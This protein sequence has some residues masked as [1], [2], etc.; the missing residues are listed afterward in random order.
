MLLKKLIKG[1]KPEYQNININDLCLDSRKAKRG[2]L[3]FAIKGKNF[4]GSCFIEEAISKGCKVIVCEKKNKIK[5]KKIPILKV[6]NIRL[7]LGECCKIFYQKKPNNIIAVTGTNGKS[8]VAEFYSQILTMLNTPVASIGTLGI[9]INNKIK[10]KNNLT[11]LDIISLHKELSRIKKN[12]VNHVILEASSHGLIQ[13]RL[14]GIE[15]NCGIFTNFSQ[16]HLDYHKSMRCY[17]FAKLILFNNLLKRKKYLITN[18]NIKEFSNLKKIIKRKKLRLLSIGNNLSTIKIASNYYEKNYQNISFEYKKKR[19]HIKI[20]LVGLFQIEN[21]F[22]AVLAVIS[23]KF[24]IRQILPKLKKIKEVNGRL[25]LIR[26]LPNKT[27]VFV[28]FAH[29]PDAIKKT[30]LTLKEHYNKNLIIIFGCG[31]ERDQKKRPLMA[32]ISED[33]CNQ[34][35]I[36]DD[37]PRNE[38]P[39]LIRKMII[40][41]FKNKTKVIEIPSRTK[42]I[43]SAILNSEPESIILVAGKGHE[44]TQIY[45]NK[46][47]NISDRKIIKKIKCK[48]LKHDKK[49]YREA[50]NKK[51]IKE[52]IN[53]KK[54]Y[55]FIGTTINS[56][57][58]KQGN[59]FIAIKGKKKDGHNY[60]NEAIKNKANYCVISKKI[61]GINNKKLINC[62]N[63][64]EFLNRLAFL[65]RKYSKAKIIAITGS[66]GKTSAKSMLG[67]I[68]SKYGK[69]FYSKKSHN[70]HYGV[71]LSLSNLEYDHEYGIFEVGM[72]R[73]GE[74]NNLS[75]L[76]QPNIAIITN[77]GEAHIENFKNIKSIANAKS[78]IIN[79]IKKGGYLILNRDDKFFNH[80]SSL[81]KKKK[82]NILSFGFSRE[83]KIK[84]VK[85]VYF[86]NH[87][88]L[89]IK[90]CGEK[91]RL[92]IKNNST[93]NEYNILICLA[94]LN[95]LKLNIK[96]IQSLFN[97][98]NSIE[99]R[100]KINKI[101]RFKSLFNLIDESYNAN[102]SSVKNAIYNFSKIKKNNQK[103]YFLLGDMRE[104]GNKT[105]LYHKKLSTFINNSDIDK[106]FI[107][108]NKALKTYQST[109]KIKRGN[110]LQN[111]QDFDEV[112]SNVIKKNDYLMIKGSN[113]TGLNNLSKNLIS[114]TKNAL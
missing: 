91:I 76:I 71:P 18:N 29:T 32:K 87:K 21:L 7:F 48:K 67:N 26:T 40:E 4:N 13:G 113:A 15:F 33:V 36:T 66:S 83:S 65:K 100:G 99:G 114:G 81:A 95:I 46:T 70:N 17:L 77:I 10:K 96:K 59:L 30:I 24:N 101:N 89:D 103:K 50:L 19:Y 110:I 14:N 73:A 90:V 42:A 68:L 54:A 85:T 16:D 63:T 55:T 51:I 3:F 47:F 1:L 45:K 64:D 49:Y 82:I 43:K 69:T 94:I 2:N 52:V 27:K 41:G 107:I 88:Y 72:S 112:F 53:K 79:N 108:G 57:E 44:T 105:D 111:L 28:D 6:N 93:I 98:L 38:D 34:I 92:Q 61:K 23:C 62:K 109:N 102:P 22:M 35:Y 8:S 104:L 97:T 39:K 20:P 58:V 9:K 37:N 80:I 25:E 60:L 75:K 86:K 12:G 74:I 5:N 31:G 78:E 11:S 106:L 56:K 84:I